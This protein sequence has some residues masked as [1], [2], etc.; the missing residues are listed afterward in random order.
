MMRCSKMCSEVSGKLFFSWAPIYNEVLLADAILHP[1]KA[2]V[3]RFL[4]SLLNI[5]VCYAGSIRIICL[6]WSSQL[7]VSHLGKCGSE[8][9]AIFRIVEDSVGF[10]FGG[11]RHHVAHDI[12]NGMYCAI[13]SGRDNGRL[14]GIIGAGGECEEATKSAA[15]FWF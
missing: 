8:R 12:T 11:G 7:R 3:H 2:H 15:Q 9:Y 5:F 14:G 13:V 1:V 6:D 10:S 4:F